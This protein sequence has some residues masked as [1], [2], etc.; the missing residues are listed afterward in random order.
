MFGEDRS[1]SAVARVVCPDDI[2][3]TTSPQAQALQPVVTRRTAGSTGISGAIVRMPPGGMSDAHM[4]AE[5]EIVIVVLSGGAVTLAWHDGV[6]QPMPHGPGEMCFV[7]AGVPHCA[8]DLSEDS[9]VLG[10]EFRTD[11]SAEQMSAAL[12]AAGVL[13]EPSPGHGVR[14]TVGTGPQVDRLV[15]AWSSRDL[16]SPAGAPALP[17]SMARPGARTG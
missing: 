11:T 17:G 13:V 4:H 12:A 15:Q 14:I 1:V 3:T 16:E 6:P 10:I 8:V 5:R 7:P 9:P 2:E